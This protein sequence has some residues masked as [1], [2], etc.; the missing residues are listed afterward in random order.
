MRPAFPRGVRFS[1]DEESEE[2]TT[3]RIAHPSPCG[4]L[5]TFRGSVITAAVFASAIII[6]VAGTI[7]YQA[8]AVERRLNDT[9]VAAARL[10]AQVESFSTAQAT[11]IDNQGLIKASLSSVERSLAVISNTH[12]P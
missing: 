4:A 12:V 10:T 6:S 2:P 9:N 8:S 1:G 7:W 5:T 3:D 11:I